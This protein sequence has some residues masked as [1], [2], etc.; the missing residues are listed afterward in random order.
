[1]VYNYFDKKA[2]DTST[3]AGTEISENQQLANELRRPITRKFKDYKIYSSFTYN[4]WGT[5][6]ADMR[7][8]HSFPMHPFCTS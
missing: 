8:T 5:D 1:M 3:H 4:I 6:L 2:G 7:L